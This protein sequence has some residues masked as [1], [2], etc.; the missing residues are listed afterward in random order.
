[1]E[2]IMKKN[3]NINSF[4]EK[5]SDTTRTSQANNVAQIKTA[6][7][8]ILIK[9]KQIEFNRKDV[10]FTMKGQTANKQGNPSCLLCDKDLK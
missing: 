5:I 1:M 3:K 8:S 7:T 4:F 6:Q 10:I 9:G 2:S